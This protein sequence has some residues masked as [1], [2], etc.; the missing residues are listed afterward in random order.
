MAKIIFI[1]GGSASGKTTVANHLKESLGSDAVLLSQDMFYKPTKDCKT[2]YDIP[3]A[4]D[5]DLQH[6]V[7]E[8]LRKGKTIEV[9]QYSF[10]K[11]DVV[12]T[13]TI[14]PS[15]IV[16]FEGLFVFLDEELRSKSDLLIYV[17]TPSDTRLARRLSR[18]IKERGRKPLE[19]IERWLKDVQ[20][21]YI[22][23]IHPMKRRADIILPWEQAKEKGLTTLI[24]AIKDIGK[25]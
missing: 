4:F 10:E 5:W 3:S 23:F 17:D 24:S 7:I 8:A 15:N 12:G 9:P 18:D 14:K 16:V 13:R 2:N 6:K 19:I 22:E 11:H 1:T 21:S 25:R 20:P